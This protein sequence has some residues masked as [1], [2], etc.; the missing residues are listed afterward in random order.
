MYALYIM[1]LYCIEG[2]FYYHVEHVDFDTLWSKLSKKEQLEFDNLLHHGNLGALLEEY[3][4]WWTVSRSLLALFCWLVT[5]VNLW[6]LTY[7]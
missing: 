3:M 7:L 5:A 1:S 6:Y 2:V 4:P